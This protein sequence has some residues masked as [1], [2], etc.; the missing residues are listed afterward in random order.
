MFASQAE[1]LSSIHTCLHRR[2]RFSQHDT[3]PEQLAKKTINTRSLIKPFVEP[4]H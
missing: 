2:Y 3:P 4:R 1:V